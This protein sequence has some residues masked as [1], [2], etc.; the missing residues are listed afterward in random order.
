VSVSGLKPIAFV[1]IMIRVLPQSLLY[2]APTA[3]AYI[4]RWC[5]I[6]ALNCSNCYSLHL[7]VMHNLCSTL[8]QLLLLTSGG[9][10]QSLLY[11]APTATPYIWRW[12]TTS[13]LHCSNCYSLHL[14]VMHNLCSTLLLLLL[15]AE[16]RVRVGFRLGVVHWAGARAGAAHGVQA[17]LPAPSA[18]R[19]G[20]QAR[21]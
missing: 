11:T 8:L 14:A 18:P 17:R 6:S 13:A 5:T 9:D 10:A 3:T 19:H 12:C 21:C 4:W 2:T 7:A 15:L 16:R 20:R 1:A